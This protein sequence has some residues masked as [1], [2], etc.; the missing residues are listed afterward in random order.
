MDEDNFKIYWTEHF[1]AAYQ[2]NIISYILAMATTAYI[3]LAI[4]FEEH[5]LVNEPFE[6]ESL[7]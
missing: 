6:P 5:D 2:F 7:P 3:L 1:C 4:Q